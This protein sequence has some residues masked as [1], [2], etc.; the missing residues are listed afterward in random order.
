MRRDWDDRARRDVKESIATGLSKGAL[1]GLS[2]LDDTHG[3]L[4]D[5]HGHLNEDTVVLEIGCG[6]GR[7]LR[8]F[9]LI[10]RQVHGIDVS[11]EMIAR[12]KEYLR[13][14]PHVKT[15]LGDGKSLSPYQSRSIDFAFSYI[16]FQHVPDKDII[17]KYVHE[18][19]RVLK[20]GGIFKFLVKYK[21]WEGAGQT[22]DTWNG[23]NV[24]FD[25]VESWRQETDFEMMGCYSLDEYLAWVLLRAPAT[26]P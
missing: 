20:P 7:L 14:F 1:F 12:S 19:R 17:R 16:V 22:P 3:I 5:I 23:V 25:D 9:A 18:A 4:R 26:G 11:P 8:F 21:D 13:A 24:S 2:G 15:C 6:I 10:F